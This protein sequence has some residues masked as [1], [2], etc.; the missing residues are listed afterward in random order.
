M[1]DLDSILDQ[2]IADGLVPE[3]KPAPTLTAEESRIVRGFIEIADFVE[4]EGRLPIVQPGA[5]TFEKMYRT[6]LEVIQAHPEWHPLVADKDPRGLVTADLSETLPPSSAP[7][8]SE[9]IGQVPDSDAAQDSIF[10]LRHVRSREE[11]AAAEEIA[12]KEACP[13]FEKFKP[14]FDQVVKDLE[15]GSRESER[16]SNERE[17]MEGQFFI[18]KGVMCYVAERSQTFE[19][20][21]RPN[22]RLR[23]VFANGTQSRLL[24]R[25]LAAELYK[26][27]AKG[28]R[29]SPRRDNLGPLFEGSEQSQTGSIYVLRS[30]SD[31]PY[32][33][34]H[35]HSLFKIGFTTGS[36]AKRIAA[37][38]TDPTYLLAP[39][40]VALEAELHN[41]KPSA[42]EKLLH[43]FFQDARADVEIKDRFG[44]PVQPREWFHVT[45][46]SIEKAIGLIR[47]GELHKHRYSIETAQIEPHF[48]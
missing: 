47:D 45:L 36:I 18:L 11:I 23:V 4:R 31:D 10:N 21:G 3:A 14:L 24:S 37:A 22:E 40:E 43:T 39:V 42:M 32:I 13:D 25:S 33:Q 35:K 9:I 6:R 12:G 20:A 7:R 34:L 2:V 17:I 8:L 44:T 48:S 16:F 27:E 1:S 46:D 5:S 41:V 28:R 30:L 15:S 19:Q 26:P 38:E 29:I